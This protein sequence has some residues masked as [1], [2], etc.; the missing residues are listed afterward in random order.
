MN[1]SIAP[2]GI[3]SRLPTLTCASRP[4]RI[5]LRTWPSFR[6]IFRAVCL[7]V[8]RRGSSS[9]FDSKMIGEPPSRASTRFLPRILIFP[10]RRRAARFVQDAP[11]IFGDRPQLAGGGDNDGGTVLESIRPQNFVSPA[12]FVFGKDKVDVQG[13]RGLSKHEAPPVCLFCCKLLYIP[14][15]FHGQ[16]GDL[17]GLAYGNCRLLN[18]EVHQPHLE[19]S[20]C[21]VVTRSTAF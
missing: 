3:M 18:H 12:V 17:L 20:F 4:S 2:R 19:N 14:S 11:T 10:S 16:G 15:S 21:R 13:R 9:G 7:M 6:P 8:R 5:S 1:R